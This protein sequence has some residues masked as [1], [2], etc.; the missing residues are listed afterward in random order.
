MKE[1]FKTGM[2][3]RS[4]THPHYDFV[5]DFVEY[6]RASYE[7]N[8]EYGSIIWWYRINDEAFDEFVSEK[9]GVNSI[10]EL[11]DSG[12]NTFPYTYTGEGMPKS[13]KAMVR[14][15]NMEYVGMIDKEVVVYRD[16]EIEYSSGFKKD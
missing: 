9:K 15:Y 4:K 1:Y 2:M 10:N 11:L 3:F 5:I 14:K 16:D 6:A 8:D 7:Q 12:K 13:I